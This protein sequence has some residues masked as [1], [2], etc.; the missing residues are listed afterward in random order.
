MIEKR[1]SRDRLRT[2]GAGFDRS[3]VDFVMRSSKASHTFSALFMSAWM[4]I[5]IGLPCCKAH[6]RLAILCSVVSLYTVQSET[7]IFEDRYAGG[8][9]GGGLLKL[10]GMATDKTLGENGDDCSLY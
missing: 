3:A 10:K 8:S 7:G 9:S 5:S 6:R 4:S 2:I 1:T